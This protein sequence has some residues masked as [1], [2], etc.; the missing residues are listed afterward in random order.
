MA[1]TVT[2]ENGQ[3]LGQ[4]KGGE[5]QKVGGAVE[6]QDAQQEEENVEP[7]AAVPSKLKDDSDSVLIEPIDDDFLND[8][9]DTAISETLDKFKEDNPPPK[10]QKDELIGENKIT[11]AS[12]EQRDAFLDKLAQH[13]KGQDFKA[14]QGDIEIARA[15]GGELT[16]PEASSSHGFH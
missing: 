11:F 15:E 12:D 2:D 16:K 4:A 14:S 1:F 5:Y 8:G 13:K 3:M 6:A 7:V 10:Y 9:L